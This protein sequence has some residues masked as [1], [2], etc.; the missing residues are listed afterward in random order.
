M[1]SPEHARPRGLWS[2]RP[3]SLRRAGVTSWT[4]AGVLMLPAL[5]GCGDAHRDVPASGERAVAVSA[6]PAYRVGQ[7]C[8]AANE[9]IYRSF[10]LTCRGS[11]LRAR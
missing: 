9:S 6:A 5:S 1:R 8:R 11:H 3:E 10:D 7:F 2:V 4:I